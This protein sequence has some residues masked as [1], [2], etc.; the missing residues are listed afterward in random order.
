MIRICLC[1]DDSSQCQR[2]R[3]Q[4]DRYALYRNIK[5][6]IVEYHS[7]NELLETSFDFD[8]VFLDVLFG[9]EKAGFPAALKLRQ[10]GCKAEIIFLTSYD[11][12]VMDGYK[13]RAFRYLLK[14]TTDEYELFGVLDSLDRKLNVPATK[15][16]FKSYFDTVVVDTE[17]II[18][19]TADKKRRIIVMADGT[20]HITN[21]SLWTLFLKL[22]ETLFVYPNQS[23]IINLKF[24]SRAKARKLIVEDEQG[25][26]AEMIIGRKYKENFL[27]KFNNYVAGILK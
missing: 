19:I 27:L 20:N 26:K 25:E 5:I 14:S 18:Y 2:L 11:D 7:T 10:Q 15:L 9:Q 22:P 3:E 8:V 12:F 23:N 4:I 16:F 21:E 6:S 24:L 1:D 17:K 13:I